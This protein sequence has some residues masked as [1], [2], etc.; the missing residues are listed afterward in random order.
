MAL[1]AKLYN[2][3]DDLNRER[4]IRLAKK[5]GYDTEEDSPIP[6]LSDKYGLGFSK[7]GSSIQGALLGNILYIYTDFEGNIWQLDKL[8]KK[9]EIE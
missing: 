9:F 1:T 8:A 3:G 6:F 7:D 4:F 5:Q 2:L